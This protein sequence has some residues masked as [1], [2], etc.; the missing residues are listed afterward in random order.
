MTAVPRASRLRASRGS[1][2]DA[3]RS[4][5]DDAA[6][7]KLNAVTLGYYTDPF[8]TSLVRGDGRRRGDPLMNRGS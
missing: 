1:P 3:V 7:C 5:N 8:I 4:T 6:I 2:D